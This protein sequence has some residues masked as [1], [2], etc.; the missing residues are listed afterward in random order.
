MKPRRK[1]AVLYDEDHSDTVLVDLLID[2]AQKCVDRA[3]NEPDQEAR[4]EHLRAARL[5]L[6]E[7]KYVLTK[8]TEVDRL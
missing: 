5:F 2:Q 1:I 7:V 8:T 4:L 3:E 6:E